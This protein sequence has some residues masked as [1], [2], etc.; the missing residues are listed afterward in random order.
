MF[1]HGRLVL[2]TVKLAAIGPNIDIDL[3][4]AWKECAMVLE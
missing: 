1:L 3:I 4:M 2:E